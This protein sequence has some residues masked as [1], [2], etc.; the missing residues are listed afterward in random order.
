[1]D[2]YIHSTRL[3]NSTFTSSCIVIVYKTFNKNSYKNFLL[4]KTITRIF[5][6]TIYKKK[7]HGK[8][9]AL[10]GSRSAPTTILIL[11]IW[12]D[13]MWAG[14]I[15]SRIG[16]PATGSCRRGRRLSGSLSGGQV[17]ERLKTL[18]TPVHVTVPVLTAVMFTYLLTHSWS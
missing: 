13:R 17:A 5:D 6:I 15:W 14:L 1:M 12:C 3:N 9:P 2:L 16:T 4:N 11:N 7:R 10:K 18:H 8:T